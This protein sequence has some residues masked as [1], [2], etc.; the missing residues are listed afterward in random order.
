MISFLDLSTIGIIPQVCG[1]EEERIPEKHH[2]GF[3]SDQETVRYQA[4]SDQYQTICKFI[5][6]SCRPTCN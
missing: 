1:S 2:L 4:E 6:V 3:S 5:G